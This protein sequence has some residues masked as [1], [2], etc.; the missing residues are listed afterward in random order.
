[1]NIYAPNMRAPKYIKQILTYLRREI[2]INAIIVGDS[3]IQ[4]STMDRLSIQRIN[5]ETLNL[6]YTVDLMH[7]TDVYRTSHPT[8][9]EYT[10]F[11]SVHY[12]QV[13]TEHSPGEI[14]W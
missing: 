3:N 13:Y 14:M 11:P 7:L 5:K 10:F 12:S 4:L 2:D 9:T 6:N 8:A 1:M